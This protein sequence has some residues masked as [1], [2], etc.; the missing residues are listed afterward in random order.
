MLES[1]I[2]ELSGVKTGVL[3]IKFR[4]LLKTLENPCLQDLPPSAEKLVV[5][6]DG[7]GATQ[8]VAVQQG[9]VAASMLLG[10][11][12]YDH[13]YMAG[14]WLDCHFHSTSSDYCGDGR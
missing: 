7:G 14:T 5:P 13:G 8:A 6:G 3:F 12:W 10:R 1:V 2:F 4:I 9:R 11:T